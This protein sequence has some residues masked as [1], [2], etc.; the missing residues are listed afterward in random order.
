MIT[1]GCRFGWQCSRFC[2][3]TVQ[4]TKVSPA[5]FRLDEAPVHTP[6]SGAPLSVM[7]W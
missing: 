2:S 6:G 5:N 1:I 3:I 4:P 7:A